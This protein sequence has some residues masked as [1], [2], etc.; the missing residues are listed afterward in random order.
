MASTIEWLHRC[1]V[2]VREACTRERVAGSRAP[3]SWRGCARWSERSIY[4]FARI[5]VRRCCSFTL[6]PGLLTEPVLTGSYA[7]YVPA[8][9]ELECHL[10]Q[11][12]RDTAVAVRAVLLRSDRWTVIF[13]IEFHSGNCQ[14]RDYA[15]FSGYIIVMNEHYHGHGTYYAGV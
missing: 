8:N 5:W 4:P 1:D 15:T 13:N 9:Y 11:F 12:P 14:V 3:P 10:L 7:F 6:L 2:G